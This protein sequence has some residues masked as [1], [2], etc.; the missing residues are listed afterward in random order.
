MNDTNESNPMCVYARTGE[1]MKYAR[2]R[3][4]IEQV[5][6]GQSLKSILTEEDQDQIKGDPDLMF[7]LLVNARLSR[8][9]WSAINRLHHAQNQA[10]KRQS[11]SDMI[12][13]KWTAFRRI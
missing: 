13:L 9:Q 7:I 1:S 12:K 11:R 2:L 3:Q 10:S 6:D 4:I 5:Y 8:S